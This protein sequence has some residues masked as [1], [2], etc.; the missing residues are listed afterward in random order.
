MNDLAFAY[1][2]PRP[3]KYHITAINPLTRL[4]EPV[5]LPCSKEKAE[6]ILAKM[7]KVSPRKRTWIYL[8]MEIYPPRWEK[9]NFEP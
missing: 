2:P 6:K 4:R 9:L 8:K 5:T 3:P 7:K 1:H